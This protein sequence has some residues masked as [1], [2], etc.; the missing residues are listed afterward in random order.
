MLGLAVGEL[1]ELGVDDQ[2]LTGVAGA[3]DMAARRDVAE[4]RRPL[5]RP[6]RERDAGAVVGKAPLCRVTVLIA[7]LACGGPVQAQDLCA[8]LTIPDSSASPAIQ[9]PT[10]ARSR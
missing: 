6:R 3:L 2:L 5:P 9:V 4:T 10:R 7:L 8:Q 1:V